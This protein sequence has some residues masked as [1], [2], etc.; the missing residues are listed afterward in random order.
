M[1]AG[2]LKAIGAIL[3]GE[4]ISTHEA[5]SPGKGSPAEAEMKA[6]STI[7]MAEDGPIGGIGGGQG[8]EMAIGDNTL[9]VYFCRMLEQKPFL[10][11]NVSKGFKKNTLK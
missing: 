1:E 10:R 4:D 11:W 7:E 5:R 3:V 2:S 8:W 6:I 9:D